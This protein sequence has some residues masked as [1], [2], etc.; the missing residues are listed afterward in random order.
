MNQPGELSYKP[1][2][3]MELARSSI[4]RIALLLSEENSSIL[5]RATIFY[6]KC[7]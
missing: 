7:S 2:N 1:D 4:G 5:L 6:V 3:I